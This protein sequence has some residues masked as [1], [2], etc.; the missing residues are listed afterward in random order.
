MAEPV[1][2]DLDRL[3]KDKNRRYILTS[4]LLG[5]V[6]VAQ[7]ANKMMRKGSRSVSYSIN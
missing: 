7:R 1:S 6:Y 5:F 2:I 4:V 3:A